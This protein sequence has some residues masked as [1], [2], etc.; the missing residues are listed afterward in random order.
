M[1]TLETAQQLATDIL[2]GKRKSLSRAITL[3]ESTLEKE[4]SVAV[5][6]LHE[7]GKHVQHPC[8]RIAVSGTPGAG[9]STFIEALGLYLCNK[10]MKVAVLSIDPSSTE[11]K[12]SILG[13]KTRMEELSRHPNAFIRPSPTS[14]NLG[15]VALHSFESMLLCEAGGFDVILI[16]TVGVGQ[17]ETEAHHLCDALVLLFAPNNGD[18]LQAIKR[19]IMEV[20]ELLVVNK[21]DGNT[22]QAAALL[23]KQLAQETHK[24]VIKCSSLSGKNIDIVWNELQA[25]VQNL[26]ALGL[27]HTKRTQQFNYW[28]K[29]AIQHK[30]AEAV[31]FYLNNKVE[32]ELPNRIISP[33]EIANIV[34]RF[35]TYHIPPHEP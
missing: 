4:R 10:G 31:Q 22:E 21:W 17:N 28:N 14:G 26:R 2:S 29:R 34:H 8:T 1:Q 16:E 33:E 23:E 18:D 11:N 24:K 13:D 27:L 15:G 19:G 9:K 3:C 35:Y 12:G 6:I 7:L 32:K 25:V 30:V 5:A 20:G